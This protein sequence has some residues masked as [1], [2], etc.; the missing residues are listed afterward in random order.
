MTLWESKGCVLHLGDCL[1]VMRGFA[2][3][4]VD[5][6]VTDPPYELGFMGKQWDASGIA[7]RVELWEAALRVLKP[8][9]HLLAFGG[10]RTYHRMACAIEDAGFEIRDSLH[11]LYGSGF[12]KSLDVSKAIDK[13]RDDRADV[14]RV[15]AF[16]AA[17][18][19]AAGKTNAE[20]DA[21]VWRLNGRKGTPG[22]AWQAAEVVGER[23]TG[24]G[25][26]R[27]PTALMRD[28]DRRLRA[29]NSDDAERWKGWG[30]AL[31][32]A[33]EPIVLARKP[34]I[35]TVARNVLEHGTGALNIDACRIG[36]ETLAATTRGVSRIG[37]FEDADGN[38]TPERVGRW[39][40]N[41][42]LD[43]AAAR[44]L[45]AQS[46]ESRSAGGSGP[47]SK[48]W[49]GDGR[50]VGAG[51]SG[52]TGGFGDFGGASRFFYV[53]KPS[54]AERDIGCEDLTHEVVNEA[55]PPGS[56][57]ANSP[58]AGAGR[59]GAVRNHHPTVKPVELM[60]HLVRLVTP[61]G[62]VVLDPFM[63]SGT[64]AF[65][66]WLEFRNFVGIE[67][68][69][70]YIAIAQ[71]RAKARAAQGHLFE[72]IRAPVEEDIAAEVDEEPTTE[73]AT[74]QAELF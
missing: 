50:T 5:A 66:A 3:S 17:A 54:R 32:P 42:L 49:R 30:T 2:E 11:W 39:P 48:N 9:G 41:V 45:D 19:D 7:Y 56:A 47:A 57:G 15:T 53:A 13:A 14:L 23:T 4:S 69:E 43:E 63:G 58:R 29:P 18:R 37:T 73:P 6:I 62:G 22:E 25:T 74:E 12:P 46:G 61:P 71:R 31:K 65:A 8:G 59:L 24:I 44:E 1:E 35:G 20:M 21:E 60:R 10:T 64:T 27:G 72:H 51:L 67:R 55:T 52:A 34:L 38:V 36:T 16:L 40:A 68:D 26:G 28:G 33:H 70:K